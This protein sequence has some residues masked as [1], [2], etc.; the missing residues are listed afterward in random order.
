MNQ[1]KE[2]ITP[3]RFDLI[4]KY[5][6]I[7]YK[8][9]NIN[10][11]FFINLY[12]SHIITFNNCKEDDK[13]N[14]DEFLNVFNKLIENMLI[15]GYN[16]NYPIPMYNNNITNGAHRLM[17]SYYYNIN[18]S[19]INTNIKENIEYN[20]RFFLY[21]KNNIPLDSIYSDTIALEF[22]KHNEN[23]RSMIL[24]PIL[25]QTNNLNNLN[26][27]ETL[28]KQYGYIYYDKSINLNKN[29][30]NN[31]IKEIYRGEEWIGGMFP[32]GFSPGGK[33]LRCIAN[34]P[35]KIILIHMNDISKC[36]E[37]KE[38]C[39]N[40]FNLGK[41]SLHISDYNED[42]FRISSSLLNNNSIHFLNKG[43]ND[44]NINTKTLLNK[45]FDFLK[46]NNEDYCVT[47]SVI[48]EM[49]GLRQAKDID[50]LQKD[51]NIIPLEKT[52][53]HDGKW[54]SYYHIHK[55]EIIYNPHYHFYFNG[56]KFS[57]IDVI[58]KMKENRN[59]PK[60]I[61]DIKLIG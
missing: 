40:L 43:T 34:Y 33:A 18:P 37:L 24:Y 44:I 13:N 36:V 5:L 52:G 11:L 56:F 21:R 1:I 41:H 20:Y 23:I 48:M 38:K 6:Y 16:S 35:T 10:T 12:K 26:N 55:D 46:N 58:K 28:I 53:I 9:K 8:D 2:L 60:D 54:L 7:K 59:E 22:I 17:I 61:N 19:F 30:I 29:G 57:S 27:L 31:L 49:Y 39:R 25:F 45:Y 50:Y 14:I 3:K 15:N 4:A 42:T 51:D 32:S 47:S